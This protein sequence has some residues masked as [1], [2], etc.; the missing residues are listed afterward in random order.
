MLKWPA[1]S[2]NIGN[3]F[4]NPIYLPDLFPRGLEV[5]LE[6]SSTFLT[7]TPSMLHL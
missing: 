6:G 4:C 5:D 3:I 7:L 2:I 1:G